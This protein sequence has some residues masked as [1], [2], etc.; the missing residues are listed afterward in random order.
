MQTPSCIQNESLPVLTLSPSKPYSEHRTVSI[1]LMGWCT[2]TAFGFEWTLQ[3]E[4]RAVHH[5]MNSS[6]RPLLWLL[7]SSETVASGGS[8]ESTSFIDST[9]ENC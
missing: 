9:Q 6:Q 7:C 3:S 4:D 8:P 2:V 5:E 1:Q